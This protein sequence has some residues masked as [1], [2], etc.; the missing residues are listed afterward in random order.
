[1]TRPGDPGEQLPNFLKPGTDGKTTYP[2]IQVAPAGSNLGSSYGFVKVNMHP[3][4]ME[5]GAERN[6]RN[7]LRW[8][9]GGG[10]SPFAP[11]QELTHTAGCLRYCNADLFALA[12]YVREGQ[13]RD[14][15]TNG[16]VLIGDRDFLV[17]LAGS[18]RLRRRWRGYGVYP[19]TGLHYVDVVRFILLNYRFRTEPSEY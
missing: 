3:I 2:V 6:R 17:A 9:G 4:M 16:L 7:R 12:D 18:Q 19:A 15:H 8:H 10:K 1:V 13:R 5:G 14:A 11:R